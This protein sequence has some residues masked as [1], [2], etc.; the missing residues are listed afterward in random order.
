ML[1]LDQQGQTFL[2]GQ[3]VIVWRGKLVL[4]RLAESRQAHGGQLVEQ[5]L[6][7]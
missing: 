5:D 4:E 6:A 3:L 2:E 7:G 1:V